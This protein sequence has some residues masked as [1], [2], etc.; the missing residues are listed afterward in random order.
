MIDVPNGYY[1]YNEAQGEATYKPVTVKPEGYLSMASVLADLESAVSQLWNSETFAILMGDLRFAY[2]DNVVSIPQMAINES[3]EPIFNLEHA[4]GVQNMNFLHTILAYDGST[5]YTSGD[6]NNGL[7]DEHL[8]EA[9]T[10]HQDLR[11]AELNNGA[12][13][14][15]PAYSNSSASKLR[16]YK[17]YMGSTN[18]STYTYITNLITAHKSAGFCD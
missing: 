13:F 16:G 17:I 18:E 11:S 8:V 12:I 14:A 4:I 3:V 7:R 10:V 5:K 6:E 2:K 9:L 1:I 15:G